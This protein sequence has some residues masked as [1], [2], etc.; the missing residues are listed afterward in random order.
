M[1]YFDPERLFYVRGSAH[2]DRIRRK[3]M[4]TSKKSSEMNYEFLD[5]HTLNGKPTGVQFQYQI[6]RLF[7]RQHFFWCMYVA[8]LKKFRLVMLLNAWS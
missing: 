7:H 3:T 8:Q 1:S 5:C 2:L 4:T 6:V